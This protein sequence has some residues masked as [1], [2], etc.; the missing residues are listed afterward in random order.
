[1]CGTVP[2]IRIEHFK[3]PEMRTGGWGVE[4][5]WGLKWFRDVKSKRERRKDW[6]RKTKRGIKAF[7]GLDERRQ[8][9]L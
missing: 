3:S 5:G 7:L 8:K 4:L 6:T 1:M 2:E 9:G